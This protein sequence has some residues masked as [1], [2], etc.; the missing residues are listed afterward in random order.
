VIRNNDVIGSINVSCAIKNDSTTYYLDSH[1]NV[2]CLF[3]FNIK[4]KET[5]IFKNN[6]LVYSSVFRKINDKVKS[7]HKVIYKNKQY[8]E[9]SAKALI[10][11][12]LNRIQNNLVSLYFNEPKKINHVYSAYLKEVVDVEFMGQGRYKVDLST[13]KYNIFHYKNGKCIKIEAFS[14]FFSVTLIPDS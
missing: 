1:I 6:M 11:L 4:G 3:T 14:R 2:K 8:H 10:P 5:S 9:K 7:K 12:D 13:G